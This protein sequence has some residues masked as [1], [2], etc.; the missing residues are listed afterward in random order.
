[1]TKKSTKPAKAPAKK[2]AALR[3]TAD[4][5]RTAL[6]RSTGGRP[7][8]LTADDRTIKIVQGLARIQCTK[9]EA[10]AVLGVTRTTFDA[11]LDANEKVAEAWS[12]GPDHGKASLRRSQWRKA[13]EGNVGMLIWL[14]KQYLGQRD[15]SE[16][17]GQLDHGILQLVVTPT[18][19][20]L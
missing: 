19:A 4:A 1:M 7:P 3:S 6:P 15:K 17:S 12:L 18:E 9:A 10:S 16:H 2:A 20:A 14:G 11:F 8:K 5:P 13:E